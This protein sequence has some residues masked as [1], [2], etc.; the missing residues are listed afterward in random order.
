[1][2]NINK[3]ITIA[4]NGIIGKRCL[5]IEFLEKKKNKKNTYINEIIKGYVFL[6]F[7]TKQ[8]IMDIKKKEKI[9]YD[10]SK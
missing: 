4:T 3:D 5:D 2:S 1:M 10:I 7:L 6:F 8:K 9:I